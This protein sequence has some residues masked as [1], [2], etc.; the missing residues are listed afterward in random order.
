MPEG[1]GQRLM[2]GR[3]GRREIEANFE[4][5]APGSDA[6]VISVR[7]LDRSFGGLEKCRR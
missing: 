4:V 6:G 5:G 1:S 7:Q 2:F 3:L